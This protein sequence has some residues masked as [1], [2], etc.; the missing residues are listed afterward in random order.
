ME[1][2]YPAIGPKNSETTRLPNN[3]TKAVAPWRPP[4]NFSK[5]ENQLYKEYKK[6]GSCFKTGSSFCILL[7]IRL[8]LLHPKPKQILPCF[9]FYHC[10]Q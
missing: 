9:L 5:L 4:L 6:R 7:I 8:Y 3:E 10:H 1:S 2:L